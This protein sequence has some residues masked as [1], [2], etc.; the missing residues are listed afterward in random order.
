M[1]GFL[2]TGNPILWLPSNVIFAF[3]R[4]RIGSCQAALSRLSKLQS[5]I[6]GT[7]VSLLSYM[8]RSVDTNPITTE[9][10]LKDALRDLNYHGVVAYFGMFFLHELNLDTRPEEPILPEIQ[11]D[12]E[13]VLRSMKASATV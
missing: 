9:S 10:Y 6:K 2:S 12:N 11:D 3:Q 1:K 4:H 7:L 8:M 5:P 13:L